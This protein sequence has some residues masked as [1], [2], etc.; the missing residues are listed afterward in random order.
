MPRR[1][2]KK[3]PSQS[4]SNRLISGASLQAIARGIVYA[5]LIGMPFHA[6][7]VV[8]LGYFIGSQL[9]FA[10]WKEVLIIALCFLALIKSVY[11]G[12]QW[13]YRPANW[14]VLATILFGV[15]GAFTHAGL[16]L[17]IAFF[18]GVKTT[19]L[20]WVLFLAVQPFASIVRWR[21]VR[22]LVLGVA[23]VVS[24]LALIQFFIVP[25]AWLQSVGYSSDTINA[26]QSVNFGG[27][28]GRTFATLGGPNQLG[29]Y[30]ILPTLW[31]LAIALTA[32]QRQKR[33]TAASG[34]VIAAAA[35]AV[36]FSRSAMIGLLIACLVLL[37]LYVPR[38]YQPWYVLMGVI[39]TMAVWTWV[40]ELVRVP[41]S[42]IQRYFSRGEVNQ[43]GV[44]IGS[45]EGHVYA[46]QQGMQLVAQSPFGQ[47]FGS[48]GPAS[49]YGG[50]FVVTENWFVQLLLEVGW[51]GAATYAMLVVELW[52]TWW[53]A[54]DRVSKVL[55]ASLVGIL[56]A[57]LFLHTWADS[58]LAIIWWALAG[59]SYGA[60]RE[61]GHDGA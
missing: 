13:V 46:W 52:R 25:T 22:A 19:V 41:G 6:F 32:E 20:P 38:K 45:D 35:L 23:L 56:I 39:S 11:D 30:L 36:T 57:N 58:T 7:V 48:A 5:L 42:F 34:A 40:Q 43:G 27:E 21:R 1:T 8:V 10:S 31:L 61:R 26:Y 3:H 50:N 44:I 37:G 24:V 12:W 16:D 18:A 54:S 4:Q 49:K 55:F 59:L 15:V 28:F 53:L 51:F 14:L 29:A 47:G 33:L 9:I 17:S 2:T 60:G